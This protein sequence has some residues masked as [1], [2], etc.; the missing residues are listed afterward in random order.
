MNEIIT[1]A[2]YKESELLVTEINHMNFYDFS[3][4][5]RHSYFE[6]F[7]FEKCGK[8]CQLIDFNEHQIE[9]QSLYIVAPNQVHLMKKEREEDGLLLQFTQEYLQTSIPE[10]NP[11][12]ML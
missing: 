1:H 6:M 5:H 7:L 10:I 12:C 3:K 2:L 11:Q 8:G 9:L 4:I